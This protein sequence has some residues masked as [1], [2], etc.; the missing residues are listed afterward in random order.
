MLVG[1]TQKSDL[2]ELLVVLGEA[3]QLLLGCLLAR[4][5]RSNGGVYFE[6]P[7]SLA[8]L[9]HAG[10]RNHWQHR[11]QQ[12]QQYRTKKYGVIHTELQ[13]K[14][15]HRTATKKNIESRGMSHTPT[16]ILSCES[17]AVTS[18]RLV[19]SSAFS[20]ALLSSSERSFERTFPPPAAA[21]RGNHQRVSNEESP[22][23]SRPD[24]YV[25]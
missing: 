17:L 1:D 9:F 15:K 6:L 19:S 7:F 24:L 22:I 23:C 8:Q 4:L 11:R 16:S 13:K 25:R 5:R 3:I 2:E 20:R 18:P 10:K 21:A 14:K 12:K